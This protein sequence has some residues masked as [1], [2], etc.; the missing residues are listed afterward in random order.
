TCRWQVAIQKIGLKADPLYGIPKRMKHVVRHARNKFLRVSST[1]EPT[2][3]LAVG[4]WPYKKS[5]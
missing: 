3:R 2:V 5:A 4:K 1:T